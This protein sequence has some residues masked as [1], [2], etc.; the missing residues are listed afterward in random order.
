M[1]VFGRNSIQQFNRSIARQ[2]GAGVS[3]CQQLHLLIDV[4]NK[5]NLTHLTA[6]HFNSALPTDS[7]TRV[8]RVV[9]C[10][11]NLIPDDEQVTL[12]DIS[13]FFPN[14]NTRGGQRI[15]YDAIVRDRVDI[16][17]AQPIVVQE[18]EQLNVL[19]SASWQTGDNLLTPTGSVGVLSVQ[20]FEGNSAS[21]EFPYRLRA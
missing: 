13:P 12:I 10:S 16:D 5:K 11:G 3:N 6:A 18:G 21:Q 7:G 20:G 19:L 1:A 8:F 14:I 9:I 15:F 17:F 4:E 2:M